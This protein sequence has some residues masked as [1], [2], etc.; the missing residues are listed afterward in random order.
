[1]KRKLFS[2]LFALVLVLSFSLIPAIPGMAAPVTQ[3]VTSDG[4][5]TTVPLS[6]MDQQFST[7]TIDASSGD[8]VLSGSVTLGNF[9]AGNGDDV[10]YEVG[11][12]SN[13]TYLG[14]S[15]LH[16]KGVYMIALYDSINGYYKVHI[17][18]VPGQEPG[19]LGNYLGDEDE[20]TSLWDDAGLC[21]FK[22]PSAT[23][24]YEIRY[25]NV[26]ASG[27]N[28]DLRI[29][30]DGGT[31]WSGWKL[32]QYA[33]DDVETFYGWS[34]EQAVECGYA[35]DDD[36]T[37]ARIVSQ[38]FVCSTTT[39]TFT[40]TYDNI[41]VNG[42]SYT[43]SP[44]VLNTNTGRGYA[45]IQPAIDD[46][47][48]GDTIN[49]AAG[50]YDLTASIIV[51]KSV[52]IIGDI[53]N[54]EN[55]VINA[56]T[57][58]ADS[59][60]KP[61]GRD[62]DA[63][64]IAT[65]NVVIKGFKIINALNLMTGP[66]DGWQN[67]G[68]AVGGDITVIDWLEPYD[69]PLLI[70]GGTFSNNIIENCSYGIYLAMS[71][72]VIVS[73]NLIRYSTVGSDDSFSANAGVG[74]M[75]WNTKAWG[76]WQ[77]PINNIIEG[78]VV[79]YSDRQ[80]ICLGAW[81]PDI[82]TVSGTVIR[83]NVIRYSSQWGD[84]PGIDLMYVTGPLGITGN[85]IYSNPTGIGVGP[86]ISGAE[87]HFN[88]IYDNTD[89]GANVWDWT[90]TAF[91]DAE[92]NWWGN[93]SGPQHIEAVPGTV[94]C[95]PPSEGGWNCDECDE[96]PDG[97]G[98]KVSDNVKYCP[99]LLGELEESMSETVAG[100]GTMGG[101][102]T[103]GDVTINATGDHTITT[104]KYTDNPGGTPNFQATGNYYD[105]HLDSDEGVASLIIEFC[106]VDEDTIIY[107]W[108]GTSWIACS[109][110][111]YA[112]GCILVTI[113]SSTVP[114][115]SDLT[116]LPFASGTPYPTPTPTPPAPGGGPVGGEVYPINRVALIAPWLALAA[117]IVA[118][119]IILARRRA[120]S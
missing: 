103:G 37:N 27:G 36:L 15:R 90:G 10:W 55:V 113:T 34:H 49:V 89:F 88:N 11:L 107:Y 65:N 13:A 7:A 61:P 99:W 50:T 78:N 100:S 56:G 97:L 62:R 30:V 47:S 42:S 67:A 73:D 28:V 8:T 5:A 19:T 21:Y 116:G 72:N 58:P 74:I 109:N 112:N 69:E 79:E 53:S 24:N 60:P 81:D 118:G 98:D 87:A 26:T 115:L 94:D 71:K 77:D 23:F 68:I 52:S 45:G 105:V 111:G 64:Q 96:N 120:H 84:N 51:N 16:N 40:A 22:V 39:Q 17:Q 9:G 83:N 44:R 91:L 2:I 29:S 86:E 101:T 48:A 33:E 43:L 1:M 12:V 38:I 3:T 119:G 20:Y 106:P 108:D 92:R 102:S 25:H 31:S 57:I 114:S 85:D 6:E 110:Q 75:N 117:A 14:Y 46:A 59:G 4:D 18:N 63:F 95:K 80:G 35:G 82:F 32:Y 104:A 70:D 54:P 93:A 66:G 41:Q 76:T